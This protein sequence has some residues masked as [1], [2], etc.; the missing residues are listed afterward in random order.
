MSDTWPWA[1]HFEAHGPYFAT[2]TCGLPPHETSEA[3]ARVLEDW[4]RGRIIATEFD[5]VIAQTRELYARLTS[6]DPATVAIGHQVSPLVGLVASAVPDG[7]EI[8]TVTGE[9]TSVTF[10]FAAQADRGVRIREVPLEGLADAIHEGVDLVAVS[11]V[12]S[13]NGA[14]ADL[15]AIAEAADHHDV[16]VLVDLTQATGWLPVDARRFAYTVCGAYKWLLSPRGTAFLTVRP[17][18]LGRLTSDQAGWYAGARP[19]DSIYGLPLRLA[20]DARRFDV[21]PAW[22]SWVG[23]HASLAFLDEIGAAECHR[24]AL[25]VEAAFATAAGLETGPSAI[26]SLV[27]DASVDALLADAD[28]VAS[29]RAGRLRLAFHVNNTVEEAERLGHLLRGHVTD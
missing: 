21:S 1:A 14:V 4:R 29:V 13:S 22:F 3:M 5:P 28:A 25:E 6:V 15:D 23:T 7:A 16:E 2:A 27:A 9:F 11:A 19:W 18:R 24:H 17:D 8:L 20:E 10:P 26:R 12:Q